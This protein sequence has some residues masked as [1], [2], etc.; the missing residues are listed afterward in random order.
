M[1]S[2]VKPEINLLPLFKEM[3]LLKLGRARLESYTYS[4]YSLYVELIVQF[5]SVEDIRHLE[6]RG[7]NPVESKATKILGCN[8]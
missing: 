6:G 8:K 4:H 5:K 2:P 7:C 3:L 1:M